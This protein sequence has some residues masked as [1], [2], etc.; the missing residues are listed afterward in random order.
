MRVCCIHTIYAYQIIKYSETGFYCPYIHTHS[1]APQSHPNTHTRTQTG[2]H[3]ACGVLTAVVRRTHS[4]ATLNKND[5]HNTKNNTIRTGVY[6][7]VCVYNR[8]RRENHRDTNTQM[9]IQNV[10]IFKTNQLHLGTIKRSLTLS[11]CTLL[12]GYC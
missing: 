5:E 11:G 3:R 12:F 6:E 10:Q 2:T 8:R 4:H 1:P 7:C 9:S